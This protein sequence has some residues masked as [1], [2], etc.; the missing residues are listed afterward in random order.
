MRRCLNCMEEYAEEYQDTCPRCGYVDG[1]TQDGT[2][3]LM[4]G[5]ILQG[6]YI[7]GTVIEARDVDVIYHGWDALFERKVQIQEYFPRYCSTRAGK[8]EVSIYDAKRDRYEAGVELFYRQSRELLRLYKENDIVTY[9]ACFRENRTAYAV[10]DY[11]TEKTLEQ[12]LDGRILRTKEASSL[13]WEMVEAVDK[14]HKIGVYHGMIGLKT[15]WVT[16]DGKLILKD[17]GAWRYCSGEPGI[18]DYGKAGIH[19]DVY[20][21]ARLFCRMITGKEIETGEKLEAELLKHQISLNSHVVSALKRALSHDTKSIRQFRAELYGKAGRRRSASGSHIQTQRKDARKSLSLPRWAVG[22]AAAAVMAIV[23][24]TVMVAVGVV[25]L[26]IQSEGSQLDQNL[27]R[28]PNVVNRDVD[29][30]EK[31]LKSMHLVLAKDRMEYSDEI[32]E[33]RV[34]YQSPKEGSLIGQGETVTVHISQGKEKVMLPSVRGIAREEAEARLKEAGFSHVMIEENLEEPGVYG[35]V[36]Q[37]VIQPDSGLAGDRKDSLKEETKNFFY[38]ILKGGAGTDSDL[39]DAANRPL[40]LDTEITL[41]ICMKKEE[42]PAKEQAAVPTVVGMGR[43]EAKSALET[44]GFQIN[45]T[46]EAGNEPAGTVVRQ[47]PEAGAV[48][49]SGSYVT[50]CISKGVEKIYMKNVTLMTEEEARGEIGKLGLATG[51]VVKDYSDT[52]A[53]GKVISQSIPQDA[54]VKKGDTV[55]LVISLGQPQ[56]EE[57]KAPASEKSSQA[58]QQSKAAAEKKRKSDAAAAAKRQSEAAEAARQQSEAAEEARRQSEADEQARKAAEAAA[59]KVSEAAEAAKKPTED[60]DPADSSR[61][62][63]IRVGPKE[64]D[65]KTGPNAGTGAGQNVVAGAPPGTGTGTGNSGEPVEGPPSEGAD[66]N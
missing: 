34:T 19:T 39:Q 17:F 40:P 31:D 7:V 11:R 44:L 22:G 36:L 48:A 23:L 42:E 16:A 41:V 46:E 59:K 2:V 25:K 54:E 1:K 45:W 62:N 8:S 63:V 14:C 20:G 6:R 47:D 21:V 55:N 5:T 66:T 56:Q 64:T 15:F 13:L 24:F 27:T 35:A 61:K 10:M 43:A 4:P 18:V 38:K 52:V 53:A 50:V 37:V 33:N 51:N 3:Y 9:H 28:V 60:K 49:A 58:A 57:T 12:W 30:V 32:A 65:S 29:E 26:K